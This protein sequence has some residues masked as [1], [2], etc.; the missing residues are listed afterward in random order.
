MYCSGRRS[1]QR[2]QGQRIIFEGKG[3]K[4]WNKKIL[5]YCIFHIDQK[6]KIICIR[7]NLIYSLVFCWTVI[8]L[9]NFSPFP[10]TSV[11]SLGLFTFL[12][13]CTV[14]NLRT[15]ELGVP[16]CSS[17]VSPQIII[18]KHK[19]CDVCLVFAE[20]RP[21]KTDTETNLINQCIKGKLM[22]ELENCLI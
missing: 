2:I 5:L 9:K 3:P 17:L 21:D 11:G 12:P 14:H 19:K 8:S 6:A 10:S 20:D 18:L 4:E 22:S 15:S 7:S 1:K 13:Q 16:V